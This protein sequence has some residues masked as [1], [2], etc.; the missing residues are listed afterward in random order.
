MMDRF[1]FGSA[2]SSMWPPVDIFENEG[3]IVYEADV[4]GAEPE[5]ITVKVVGELLIIEGKRRELPEESKAVNYIC[6]ERTA[7]SFRRVLAIPAPVDVLSAT[8]LYERG[9][10]T[11]RFAKIQNRVH[12][13]PVKRGDNEMSLRLKREVVDNDRTE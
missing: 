10:L 12:C 8:S 9:V 11:V 2:E 13:I 5:D 4:P 7:R 1:F 3:F 6:I